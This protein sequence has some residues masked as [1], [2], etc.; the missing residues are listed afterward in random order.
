MTAD[1]LTE[2]SFEDQCREW[3]RRLT[4][5]YATTYQSPE[6][7]EW[8]LENVEKVKAL[9]PNFNALEP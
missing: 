1:E 6:Y 2:L 8:C 7:L 4:A 5:D 3:A 9:P